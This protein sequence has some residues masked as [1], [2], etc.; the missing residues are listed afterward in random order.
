MR[1]QVSV[2]TLLVLA[3]LSSVLLLI[4][5]KYT[6]VFDVVTR[7]FTERQADYVHA[8]LSEALD[9]CKSV[10]LTLRFPFDVEVDCPNGVVR[11]GSATR[12][13][14]CTGYARGRVVRIEN[15]VIRTPRVA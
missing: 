9:S 7:G 14:P 11:V 2:E 4:A 13:I 8:L 12:P 15:C 1:G 5:S 6:D 3:V 10:D